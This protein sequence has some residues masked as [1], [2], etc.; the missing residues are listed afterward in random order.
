MTGPSSA[1]RA[2]ATDRATKVRGPQSIE[3]IRFNPCRGLPLGDRKCVVVAR[4]CNGDL[5]EV[6]GGVGPVQEHNDAGRRSI[7]NQPRANR[8]CRSLADG[9]SAT[10]AKTTTRRR[11][12]P[13]PLEQRAEEWSP[14]F[15]P[16][17]LH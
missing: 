6:H 10:A 13:P 11:R 12:S 16:R 8:D 1:P 4:E 3:H 17:F 15:C 2:S 5:E 7:V 14:T 9:A